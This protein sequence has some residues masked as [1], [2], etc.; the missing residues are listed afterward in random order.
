MSVGDLGEMPSSRS[1]LGLPVVSCEQSAI[2][3]SMILCATQGTLG[4]STSSTTTD[5]SM[6][7]L[8]LCTK[9]SLSQLPQRTQGVYVGAG[10]LPVPSKL[11]SRI[12]HWEF[13]N[14]ADLLPEV[15]LSN[16]EGESKKLLQKR[17]H[18]VTDIW[19]WLHCFGT[20]VSVLG[21]CYPQAIP[22]LMAYMSLIIRCSQDYEGLAWVSYDNMSFRRQAAA[23]GNRNWLE[24]NSTYC[25]QFV[26]PGNHGETH[27]VSCAWRNCTSQ[28]IAH[29]KGSVQ[30]GNWEYHFKEEQP[31][32]AV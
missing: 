21:P 19:S 20:Y 9:P 29:C 27:N 25:I 5:T 18:W 2:R 31:L 14:M 12:Q 10:N 26:S 28:T 3:G 15:G 30:T 6:M 13:I 23:S 22:E 17:P 8:R 4:I 32:V 16:R 11:V 1:L 7:R 24:V